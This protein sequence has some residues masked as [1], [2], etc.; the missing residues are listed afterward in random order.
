EHFERDGA[1][2]I[3][4]SEYGITEVGCAVHI[5]RVLRREGLL[6][7]RDELG[8]DMLDAGASEA[9]AVVDHQVAHIYVK[10][11]ERIAEVRELIARQPGVDSVLDAEGKKAAGI[12]HPRAG[13]LVAVST[14]DRWFS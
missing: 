13:D 11:P 5:N 10:R 6:R 12:D 2:V 14:A 9:F 1:R 4:L 3:I 7:V 8:R